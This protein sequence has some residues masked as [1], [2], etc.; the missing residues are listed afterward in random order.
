MVVLMRRL[1]K[2][3]IGFR[4]IM[5]VLYYIRVQNNRKMLTKCGATMSRIYSFI[6]LFIVMAGLH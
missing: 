4:G 6:C 1:P 5:N 3:I 2:F